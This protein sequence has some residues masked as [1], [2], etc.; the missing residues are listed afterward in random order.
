MKSIAEHELRLAVV[1]L[2]MLLA[3]GASEVSAQGITK[4]AVK[5]PSIALQQFA[6][7]SEHLRNGGMNVI[8][9]AF[10][11]NYSAYTA[12]QRQVLLDGL[13]S[14]ASDPRTGS[15][16]LNIRVM[17]RSF[18][19]LRTIA[20]DTAIHAGE[21]QQIGARLLRIYRTSPRVLSRSMAVLQMGELLDKGWAETAAMEHVLRVVASAPRGPDSVHPETAVT[22]L[23]KAGPRGSAILRDLY[24]S[25]SARD[26]RV[27]AHLRGLAKYGFVE[28]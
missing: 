22:A 28:Q 15:E 21:A 14:M 6:S 1:S 4:F 2:A 10:E 26:P 24:T 7:P 13:T 27:R 18:A 19:M 25:D 23:L 17:T 16:P 5:D 11:R 12:S 8:F 9:G 20:M 3:M